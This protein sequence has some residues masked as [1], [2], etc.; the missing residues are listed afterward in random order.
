MPDAFISSLV[1]KYVLTHGELLLFFMILKLMYKSD[2]TRLRIQNSTI[3]STFSYRVH[4][5]DM[6]QI[7]K[8]IILMSNHAHVWSK[9]TQIKGM[10]YF[11]EIAK[12]MS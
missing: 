9:T 1:M 8:G 11:I 7:G 10:F 6:H 3:S 4:L 12:M 2:A 5:S